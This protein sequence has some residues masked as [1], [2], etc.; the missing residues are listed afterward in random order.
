MKILVNLHKMTIGGS[1]LVAVRLADALKKRGHET[2]IFGP[3]G[4]V[5]ELAISKGLRFIGQTA[6]YRRRP[7]FRA[8]LAL[9][10]LA[11]REGVDLVHA[12]EHSVCI[13]AFFGAYLMGGKPLVCSIR[14]AEAL[15]IPYPKSVPIIFAHQYIAEDARGSGFQHVNQIRPPVDVDSD[16]PSIDPSDF[17]RQY[18][19]DRGTP[20]VVVITRLAEKA[21][22]DGLIVAI[23]A[24][25]LLAEERPVRLVIVGDGITHQR[26]LA[27][28]E[29]VN[30]RLGRQAIVFTGSMLDPRPAYAAADIVLGMQGSL[31]RGMAF[32]KP[33]VVL[34][35]QGYSEI[36]TPESV[37]VF[38]RKSFYGIGDGDLRPR[39]LCNQ[40][41][42]LLDDEATRIRLGRFSRRVVCEHASL[43]AA[44]NT[45]EGIYRSVL[46]GPPPFRQRL[47][48][49]ARFL[50]D[51]GRGRMARMLPG[52]RTYKERRE[53]TWAR[54]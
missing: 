24:I 50:G 36:V 5:A 43:N 9:R 42:A 20:N 33:A 45:L 37:P 14:G 47:A 22:L 40:L 6:R 7:S 52:Y 17:L 15:P 12:S 54:T 25:E 35:E 53:A 10:S 51:V 44:A 34:G 48:E 39:R 16:H 31:L 23:D 2:I 26:L 19:L 41:R 21:K 27:R 13:E 49:T 38:L 3:P 28:G 4:P 29:R 8:A 30:S 1:Q 32:E 11:L 18:G 46:G